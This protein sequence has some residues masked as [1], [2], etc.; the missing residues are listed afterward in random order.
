MAVCINDFLPTFNAFS[1]LDGSKVLLVSGDQEAAA[2]MNTKMP[3]EF[4]FM[5][6][7]DFCANGEVVVF[8]EDEK[9][10]AIIAVPVG[11]HEIKKGESLTQPYEINAQ[12]PDPAK[13]QSTIIQSNNDDGTACILVV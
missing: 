9:P 6:C 8:L 10:F 7:A 4:S 2:V 5:L 13:R 11:R 3:G 12:E 1:G